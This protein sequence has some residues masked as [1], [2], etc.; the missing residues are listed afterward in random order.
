MSGTE[1]EKTAG[2]EKAKKWK[3]SVRI[4]PVNGKQGEMVGDWL[5]VWIAYQHLA[6][7]SMT[8]PFYC[9]AAVSMHNNAHG[10]CSSV[11]LGALSWVFPASMK[12][13]LIG[14]LFLLPVK[15]PKRTGCTGAASLHPTLP[16]KLCDT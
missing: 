5:Q 14:I 7:L 8:W 9:C 11:V 13:G 6:Q 16:F 3:T 12:T 1:F 4:A 2:R 15:P 10:R